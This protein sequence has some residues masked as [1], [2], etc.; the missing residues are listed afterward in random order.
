MKNLI[1]MQ[2]V[3]YK[4][5]LV[6]FSLSDQLSEPKLRG[7]APMGPFLLNI[8]FLFIQT[9]LPQSPPGWP[10]IFAYLCIGQVCT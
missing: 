3:Q 2:S 8:S 4:L 9:N 7:G 1:K 6:E 5:F 10:E